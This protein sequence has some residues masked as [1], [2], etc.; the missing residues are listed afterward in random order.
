MIDTGTFTSVYPVVT[1]VAGIYAALQYSTLKTLRETNNDLR[2][3]RSDDERTITELKLNIAELQKKMAEKDGQI[4]V[5][6]ELNSGIVNWT[7]INDQVSTHNERV[8]KRW[9]QEDQR[10]L[11]IEKL[12]EQIRDLTKK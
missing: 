11:S 4:G 8:E 5:L 7:L 12:L 9:A 6:K 1:I 10:W 2:D 3:K